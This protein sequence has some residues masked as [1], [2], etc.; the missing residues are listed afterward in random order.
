MPT[1]PAFKS[2]VWLAPAV[3]AVA[4]AAPA[5]AHRKAAPAQPRPQPPCSAAGAALTDPLTAGGFGCAS[6]TNLRLML[7]EPEDLNAG[8]PPA[9]PSGDAALAAVQRHRAGQVKPL[10]GG[11]SA[12]DTGLSGKDGAP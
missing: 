7:A 8:K 3:I 5:A 6:D 1:P 12:S 11:A 2:L 9:P 10:G 4:M